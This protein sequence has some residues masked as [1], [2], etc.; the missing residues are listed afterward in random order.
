MRNTTSA[1]SRVVT[2]GRSDFAFWDFFLYD[3]ERSSLIARFPVLDVHKKEYTFEK[4]N[5]LP[6]D[7]ADLVFYFAVVP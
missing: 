3:S 1:S 5:S 6:I 7:D 2:F 4:F